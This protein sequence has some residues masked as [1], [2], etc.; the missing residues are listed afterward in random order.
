MSVRPAIRYCWPGLLWVVMAVA[1]PGSRTSFGPDPALV[2]GARAL[3]MRDFDSGIRLTLEGLAGVIDPKSR[4][5]ALNN[6][7]AGYVGAR[8]YKLAIQAC[9]ASLEIRPLNWRAHSN[10]AL[11]YL[12]QGRFAEAREDVEAGL[13]VAPGA[14]ALQEVA[15]R[16]QALEAAGNPATGKEL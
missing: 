4:A 3:R 12:G 10:R 15:K 1:E 14:S 13:R 9:D 11:A 2:D 16:L 8:Q 6:L 5:A 7:C